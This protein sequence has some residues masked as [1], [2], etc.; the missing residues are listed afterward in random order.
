MKISFTHVDNSLPLFCEGVGYTW[1]Q[2]EVHRPQGHHYY[3]WLQT[4]KGSGIVTVRG[5][6]YILHPNQGLLIRPM[7]EHEYHQLS[8]QEQWQ[9]EFLVFGGTVA[10]MLA[11]FLKMADVY[12]LENMTPDLAVFIRQNYVLFEHEGVEG[13]LQQSA[14]LYNFVMLLKAN[15]SQNLTTSVTHLAANKMV[16]MITSNYS[17]K[18]SAMDLSQASGYSNSYQNKIFNHYYGMSPQTF[19]NEYRLRQ[20][21]KLMMLHPDWQVQFVADQTGFNDIS[22]FIKEFKDNTGMTPFNFKQQ[23]LK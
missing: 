17:D 23:F 2:D 14:A 3:H 9:T 6:K 20:A 18:I 22:R 1:T 16:D 11:D 10:D 8:K 19:L 21:K 4:E 5:Q 13:T 15:A 12:Y 7:I